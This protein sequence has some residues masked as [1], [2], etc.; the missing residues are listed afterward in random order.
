V[1]ERLILF[2]SFLST[3]G[4]V[5]TARSAR[6]LG[7]QLAAAWLCRETGLWVFDVLWTVWTKPLTIYGGQSTV[8]LFV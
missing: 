7:P 3:N 5:P 4:T 1:L 6:V 8:L 2:D